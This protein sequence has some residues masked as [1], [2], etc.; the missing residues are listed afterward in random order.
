MAKGISTSLIWYD[1]FW[2]LVVTSTGRALSSNLVS[3]IEGKTTPLYGL[4][5]VYQSWYILSSSFSQ[6]QANPI[7]SIPGN[8]GTQNYERRFLTICH[9]PDFRERRSHSR[10]RS[11]FDG[12]LNLYAMHI[13]FARRLCEKAVLGR[14]TGI[15]PVGR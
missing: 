2:K 8:V 3:V 7:Y 1:V 5:R 6:G 11:A 10:K 12:R 4:K 15:I 9:S 13:K 14:T